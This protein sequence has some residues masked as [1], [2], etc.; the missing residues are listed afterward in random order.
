MLFRSEGG[1]TLY[2]KNADK[3]QNYV[4]IFLD[5]TSSENILVKQYLYSANVTHCFDAFNTPHQMTK[6]L[7]MLAD[8]QSLLTVAREELIRPVTGLELVPVTLE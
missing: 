2:R 4:D 7:G 6:R 1:Y 3:I 8:K 5:K